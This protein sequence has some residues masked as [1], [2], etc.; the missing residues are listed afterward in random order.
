MI[1][2]RALLACVVA[3]ISLCTGLTRGRA[4]DGALAF[5]RLATFSASD[6]GTQP[7]SLI[8]GADGF[9]YGTTSGS[10]SGPLATNATVFKLAPGGEL[11]ILG[12]FDLNGTN[13]L[14]PVALVHSTDSNFY[15]ATYYG[16]LTPFYGTI[17]KLAPGGVLSTLFAFAG[18]NGRQPIA[19]VQGADGNLYGATRDGGDFGYGTV[20]KLTTNGAMTPLMSFAVTNGVRP[21]HL[22]QGADGNLYGTTFDD[23][24]VN[25]V[26]NVFKLSLSGEFSI[27]AS[28]QDSNTPA[29]PTA[30]VQGP[31]GWLYVASGGRGG[32]GNI[33]KVS[34]NG[35][36]SLLAE[37]NGTNGWFPD[38]L[39]VGSD[40]NLYGTT[41]A[42]G[43]DYTPPGPP[44]YDIT[45]SGTIFKIT[46]D[47][48]LT[49]LLSFQG[50]QG[51]DPI[52]LAQTTDGILYCATESEQPPTLAA[53]FRLAP[54][55]VIRGLDRSPTRDVLSWSSF[56]GGNYQVEY[57]TMLSTGAWSAVFP[58]IN[59]RGNS[60]SATNPLPLI[61]NGF[62]RVRL[63]P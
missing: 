62:Y 7:T 55:P 49:T 18:P 50:T 3:L 29:G 21:N 4:A 63:L 53:I 17:F 30:I 11:T 20:F 56:S 60:A 1:F 13:G 39:L 19:L 51:D 24:G 54:R 26:D 5:Q 40:G 46:L 28:G 9:I 8:R 35:G 57:N 41:E 6:E 44:D 36:A 32:F 27:L 59:A 42:G 58:I 45:G 52:L 14:K 34:T 2:R 16:G 48:A 22:I 43:A 47:G 33:F 23:I 31:D 10:I 38:S 25:A 15:G 61:T 37:F 12:S